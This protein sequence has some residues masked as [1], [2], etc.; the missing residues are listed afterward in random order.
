[1]KI[2][3]NGIQIN[4]TLDGPAGAPVVT[5]SHSL[6]TTLAMW[7]PQLPALSERYRVLRYDTRGHGGT[8]APRGAYTLEQLAEDAR[9]LLAAL[10]IAKAHWVGLSMGGMIGQTLALRAPEILASLVLCDTSSRVPPEMRSAWDERIRTAET[11]GM[12]PLVEPT[13]GRWFTPPF[14]AR[15]PEVVERVRGMIRGSSPAGYVGCCHAISTLDLTDR[16]DA[17]KV[18]TLIIVGEDDQGTPVAA[19]QAIQAR[20]E[21]SRLVVLKAAA[22]LS[23]LEQ[24][25]AFT[26]ALTEFLARIDDGRGRP[27]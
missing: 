14:R 11:Q 27:R 1:M 22:H 5:L 15:R 4:Y 23:N 7:D 6:A 24:P 17:I 12:E 19:S 26:G 8:D 16:L 21:G 9:A 25:E 13:L 2:R 10:G 20:I 18:P 3:A